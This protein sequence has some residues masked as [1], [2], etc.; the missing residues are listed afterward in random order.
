ME[1][2]IQAMFAVQLYVKHSYITMY[3]ASFNNTLLLNKNPIRYW[4][5]LIHEGCAIGNFR[6]TE[7]FQ[8]GGAKNVIWLTTNGFNCCYLSLFYFQNRINKRSFGWTPK[9]QMDKVLYF[10]YAMVSSYTIDSK[11]KINDSE[12]RR[13]NQKWTVQKKCAT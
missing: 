1:K 12:H 3:K 13:G 6:I 10:K 8:F 7:S 2:L 9:C 5:L 4:T 11:Y